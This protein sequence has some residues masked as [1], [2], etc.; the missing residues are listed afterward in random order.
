VYVRAYSGVLGIDGQ[1]FAVSV[2]DPNTFE[3]IAS[4]GM[5]TLVGYE[6]SV[7]FG[8]ERALIVRDEGVLDF[9][10]DGRSRDIVAPIVI[11][12]SAKV[13]DSKVS[14]RD[15]RLWPELVEAFAGLGLAIEL[16]RLGR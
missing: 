13:S 8:V 2:I 11:Q 14:V 7:A 15:L 3:L 1:V 12:G 10:S 6:G 9:D 4:K 16:R 5:G